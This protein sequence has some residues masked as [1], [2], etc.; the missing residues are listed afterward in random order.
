MRFSSKGPNAPAHG[1]NDT[2]KVC[3]EDTREHECDLPT[4]GYH[5]FDKECKAILADVRD[6]GELLKEIGLKQPKI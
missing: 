1:A 5:P 4:G 2:G 3:A 6:E